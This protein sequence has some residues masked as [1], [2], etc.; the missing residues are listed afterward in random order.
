M[1]H[2]DDFKCP[3]L[4]CS[5]AH[6]KP[7]ATCDYACDNHAPECAACTRSCFPLT[8]ACTSCDAAMCDG[9]TIRGLCAGCAPTWHA[10]AAKRRILA[11]FDR[12][13]GAL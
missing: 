5:G 10:E 11:D 4:E 13:L 12:A 1:N 2:D 3:C 7:T 6:C 9:C 8:D